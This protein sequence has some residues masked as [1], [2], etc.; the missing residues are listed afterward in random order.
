[1]DWIMIGKAAVLGLIQGLTELLPISSTGHL[2]IANQWLGTTGEKWEVFDVFIHLGTLLAICFAYC[3]RLD[4]SVADLLRRDR[5]AWR[6]WM[7]IALAAVPALAA[8]AVGSH[9]IKEHLYKPV[10]VAAALFIGA[11]AIFAIEAWYRRRTTAAQSPAP[12]ALGAV[13]L[14]QA[15]GI[16]VVQ[17]LALI[18]GTS[19]SGA[20]IMGGM[21]FGL[22]RTAATDFSFFLAMPMLLAAAAH[23]LLKYRHLLTAADLLPFLVGFL[24]AFV[25]AVVVVKWLLRFIATHDFCGFAWYRIGLACAVLVA[26]GLWRAYG[27]G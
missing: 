16:G 7:L 5:G 20:T 6:F 15:L 12:T 14:R 21:A 2:I 13:T 9:A 17:I 27:A 8:G 22:S 23:D 10:V 19:R 3:H 25:S 11:L 18:P 1:M 26:D 24:M 4:R